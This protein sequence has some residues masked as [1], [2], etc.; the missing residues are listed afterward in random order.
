MIDVTLAD[1]RARLHEAAITQSW[2]EG[3]KLTVD[4]AVALALES[5]D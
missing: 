4:E 5:D 1:I 2:E 3:R